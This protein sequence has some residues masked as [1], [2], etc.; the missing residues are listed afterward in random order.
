MMQKVIFAV[1]H[2]LERTGEIGVFQV[3]GKSERSLL[4]YP[5]LK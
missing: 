3:S 2:G 1:E 4:A 5:P